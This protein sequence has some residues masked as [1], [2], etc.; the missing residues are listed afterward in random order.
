MEKEGKR[1]GEEGMWLSWK[2]KEKEEVEDE[3]KGVD[4]KQPPVRK[5]NE[6]R[7]GERSET[8][9]KVVVMMTMI[10]V[11]KTKRCTLHYRRTRRAWLVCTANGDSK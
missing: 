1:R 8:N 2:R 4:C 6:K 10:I 9:T 7:R 11:T 5:E 3:G